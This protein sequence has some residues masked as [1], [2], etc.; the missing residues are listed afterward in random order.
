M[1][2]AENVLRRWVSEDGREVGARA[3]DGRK[4]IQG[5]P[6]PAAVG[7]VIAAKICRKPRRWTPAHP[8]I[9]YQHARPA[10]QP[11]FSQSEA[12]RYC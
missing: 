11:P 2:A 6:I 5:S 1:A 12:H 4:I 9:W 8:T 10:S 7:S 3:C